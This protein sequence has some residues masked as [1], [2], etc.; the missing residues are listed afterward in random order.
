MPTNLIQAL[1]G[2]APKQIREMWN[3][4]TPMALGMG[5]LGERD[6][7]SPDVPAARRGK[8]LQDELR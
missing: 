4:I 6:R 1:A 3:G 8:Y 5:A 2:A 7:E